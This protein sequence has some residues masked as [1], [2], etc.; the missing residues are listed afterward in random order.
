MCLIS[1]HLANALRDVIQAMRLHFPEGAT[2][3]LCPACR[4]PVRPHK[5]GVKGPAA[6]F[7]HFEKNPKCR[8]SEAGRGPFRLT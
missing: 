5:A 8:L 7:E 4:K 2:A 1:V 3:F 6:H